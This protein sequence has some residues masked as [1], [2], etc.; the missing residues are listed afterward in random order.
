MTPRKKFTMAAALLG[1]CVL[2]LSACG[3]ATAGVSGTTGPSTGTVAL[4]AKDDAIAALLPQK[5]RDRGTLVLATEAANPPHVYYDTDGATLIGNEIEFGEQLGAILGLKVEWV[6][7][8]FDAILPGLQAGRYDASI[9]LV[10]DTKEREEVVDMVSYVRA[11]TQLFA[12]KENANLISSPEELCGRSVAVQ[13]GTVL[14]KEATRYSDQCVAAGEPAVD[15][16]IFKGK[17]DQVQ[18]VASGQVTFGMQ[19][20]SHNVYLAQQ[21]GGALVG[22]GELFGMSDIGIP[23][24]KDSGMTEPIFQAVQ[25]LIASPQYLQILQNWGLASQAISEPKLNGATG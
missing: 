19:K 15:I 12:K 8:T 11:A 17:T 22:F 5:V 18:A 20:E 6:N 10:R 4:I 25:K 2:A 24:A 23:V 16:K 9:S 14:E 1:V 21:T 7:T 3:T 13:A